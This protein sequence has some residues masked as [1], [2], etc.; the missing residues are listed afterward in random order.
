MLKL[1]AQLLLGRGGTQL[2]QGG[3]LQWSRTG[4]QGVELLAILRRVVRM[5]KDWGVPTWMVKL[6]IQKA[7][8]S[9]SQVS[10]AQLIARKVGGMSENPGGCTRPHVGLPW[11]ARL[12]TSLLQARSLHIATGDHI[13]YVEQTNGVRQGSPD[14]PVVFGALT[15]EALDKAVS[16]TAHML[17]EARGPPPPEQ[18]GAYMDDTYLWSH[19]KTHLQATLTALEAQLASHGFVI[20]PKKTAIIHSEDTDGG[21]LTIGGASVACLP[22]GS[23]ITVL[24]SPL[25]FGEAVPNL[26]AEMQRRGR[27]AFRQHKDILCARTDIR[28]RLTAYSALVRNAALWGGETW[29]VHDTLLKQANHMQMDHLRQMLHI[30]RKPG[31]NWADWNKRS[32]RQARVQLHKQRATRWSSFI[33]ERIWTFWGHLVRGGDEVRSMIAWKDLRWWREQQSMGNRGV[34]HKHRFNSNLD[35][36]R[37]LSKTGGGRWMHNALNREYWRHLTQTFVEQHDVPWATGRQPKLENLTP[38]AAPA[39]RGMRR[40]LADDSFN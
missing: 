21:T 26:V 34:K 24:G 11:E 38:T 15:A 37:A 16:Q 30:N 14:S 4:R 36:E 40:M 8:D 9:V 6:D 31:E 19:D 35:V 18:G 27:T 12:W 3:R 32:L 33:L 1:L 20:N 39:G 29:P 23:T 2:Q 13:T 22:Y 28:G 10:M 7:F 5:A 25:T 17:G